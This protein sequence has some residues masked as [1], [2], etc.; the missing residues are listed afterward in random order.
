MMNP[1]LK[2]IESSFNFALFHDDEVAERLFRF[3]KCQIEIE[4]RDIKRNFLLTVHQKRIQ[5]VEASADSPDLKISGT[6][7]SLLKL[8]AKKKSKATRKDNSLSIQGD[9]HLLQ[10]LKQI[11]DDLDFDLETLLSPYLGDFLSSH[12]SLF[13]TRTKHLIKE[14]ASLFSNNLKTFLQEESRLLADKNTFEEWREQVS[15][16]RH[17]VERLEAKLKL[18]EN[19]FA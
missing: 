11:A 5:L 15:T 2:M 8:A 13:L 7:P 19:D 10:D 9:L 3:E 6:I 1:I 16:I 17:D 12:V 18:I 14:N 4:L